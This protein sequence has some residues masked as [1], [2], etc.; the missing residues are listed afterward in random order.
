MAETEQAPI[1]VYNYINGRLMG[2]AADLL[3][4]SQKEAAIVSEIKNMQAMTQAE[5]ERNGE[6][7][8]FQDTASAALDMYIDTEDT[9]Q[10]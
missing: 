6:S 1:I 5:R 4:M 3:P 10:Q 2:H 8:I 7:V 9:K